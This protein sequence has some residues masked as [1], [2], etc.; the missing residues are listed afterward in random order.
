MLP[1]LLS[2]PLHP[3]SGLAE[4][5]FSLSDEE[6]GDAAGFAREERDVRG[7]EGVLS[8]C[9]GGS[10]WIR[11][12]GRVIVE[13]RKG[14]SAINYT[15]RQGKQEEVVDGGGWRRMEAGVGEMGKRGNSNGRRRGLEDGSCCWTTRVGGGGC[16]ASTLLVVSA[17]S[18]IRLGPIRIK[19]LTQATKL[20][21]EGE[22]GKGEKERKSRTIKRAR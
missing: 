8:Q 21:E 20:S 17:L 13:G 14:I 6:K 7:A 12:E 10:S 16:G 4:E 9:G 5:E 1:F 11:S 2:L 19:G 15:Q 18:A 3:L 22:R